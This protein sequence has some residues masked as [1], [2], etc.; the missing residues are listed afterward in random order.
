MPSACAVAEEQWLTALFVGSSAKVGRNLP[1]D[2]YWSR[3]P[4]DPCLRK[5]KATDRKIRSRS[6]DQHKPFTVGVIRNVSDHVAN[7][8][9]VGSRCV[10]QRRLRDRSREERLAP[11]YIVVNIASL[12]TLQ[13]PEPL[14][15]RRQSGRVFRRAPA[16]RRL[17]GSGR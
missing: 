13:L 10:P 2:I 14:V 6:H 8:S 16:D 7:L 15:W 12:Y 4:L 9:P 1:S 17:R 11:H 3:S 5:A